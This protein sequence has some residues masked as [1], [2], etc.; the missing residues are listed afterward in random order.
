[1]QK[2]AITYP[3][4]RPPWSKLGKK[5][6]SLCR[7]ALYDFELLKG[8]DK[9]AIAL[10]G[11]KDSLALLFLLKAIVGRGFPNV[12]LIAIHIHGE[13]SCG[14]GIGLHLLSGICRQLDVPFI[15]CEDSSKPHGDC[16]SCSRKRRSLLFEA[17]KQQSA[18]TI[19]FGHH[20]DDNIQTL[21]MNLLHKG[22]FSAMLPKIMLHKFEVQVIRPLIYVN[23]KDLMQFAKMHGFFRTV[24]VCPI[25]QTSFRKKTEEILC[26]LE[27]TFPNAR[28][29]LSHA[30]LRYGTK[31]ATLLYRFSFK[32]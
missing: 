22:E 32:S 21:L 13:N 10:S 12:Q 30:A 1:M 8:V 31:K 26:T 14:A 9:L 7:K 28:G 29:N 11:G 24:C 6:E 15:V 17:A 16:Y 4:A 3:C 27:E 18:H 2:L 5:L 23:P 19:A 20:R 25:G